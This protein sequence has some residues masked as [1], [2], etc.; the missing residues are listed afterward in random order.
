[1][2]G[3]GAEDRHLSDSSPG[4]DTPANAEVSLVRAVANGNDS[5]L[6]ELIGLYERQLFGFACRFLGCP[7]DA[8]E[9]VRDT[10]LAIWR[11]APNFRGGAS[12]KT[13]IY[14]I[15][16]NIAVSKLRQKTKA[17]ASPLPDA[18][19]DDSPAANPEHQA[20]KEYRANLLARCI[21]QLPPAARE[22]LILRVYQELTYEEI[23]Q[24]CGCPLGT[25]RS[26]INYAMTRLT[27]IVKAIDADN[28]LGEDEL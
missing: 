25:V 23:A 8:E 19:C 2:K 20:W 9:V 18:V 27:K 28:C 13:W 3:P 24:A 7:H 14:S 4:K 17:M 5:A 10:F 15:C 26:R 12:V 11:Q 22:A 16:R 6:A 21:Q 1:M